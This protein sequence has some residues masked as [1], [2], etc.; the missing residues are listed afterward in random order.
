M[1]PK[2][3]KVPMDPR[4]L[5]NLKISKGIDKEQAKE[6]KGQPKKASNLRRILEIPRRIC[7]WVH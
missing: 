5:K 2:M 3:A 6:I 4:R 7:P 1:F